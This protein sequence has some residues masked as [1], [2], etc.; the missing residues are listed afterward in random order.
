MKV[1]Y[2]KVLKVT[3]GKKKK[4]TGKNLVKTSYWTSVRRVGL[5]HFKLDLFPS[6]IPPQL[7]K[8]ILE[9]KI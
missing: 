6:F 1:D 7:K 5:W 2:F 4:K 9:L 3:E 8:E